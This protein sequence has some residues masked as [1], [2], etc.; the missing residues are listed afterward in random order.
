MS[1]AVS[2]HDVDFAYSWTD[3]DYIYVMKDGRN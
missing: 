2:T 3:Y 1:I